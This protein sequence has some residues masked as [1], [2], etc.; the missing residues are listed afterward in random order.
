[1]S[2]R[3]ETVKPL[4]NREAL[5]R[6]VAGRA[7]TLAE[8]S[9]NENSAAKASLAILRRS[10]SGPLGEQPRVWAEVFNRFPEQLVGISDEPN[11]YERAA[12]L[13]LAFFAI[14]QQSRD[15]SMHKSGEGFGTAVAKLA[16]AGEGDS[17]KKGPVRRFNTIVTA[18]TNDELIHHMRGMIQLLRASRIPLDYGTLA[19]DFVA[20]NYPE[21]AR[22]VRLR[23]AR[24]L[25][26]VPVE[27]SDDS[28]ADQ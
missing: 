13:A 23:W 10:I 17:E 12:H 14:H 1:M 8:G 5:Y 28:T 11:V 18:Q 9:L 7:H 21:S 20:L 6:F 22:G 4:T 27:S 2:T 3:T 19:T 25:N 26:F 16:R 15:T 24:Q